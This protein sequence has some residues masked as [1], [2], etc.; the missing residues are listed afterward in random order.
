MITTGGSIPSDRW[1]LHSAGKEVEELWHEYE[2]ASSPEA[3][4]VKDFDKARSLNAAIFWSA[5]TDTSRAR[6]VT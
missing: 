2:S 6:T 1:F 3:Q 4:L 5:V